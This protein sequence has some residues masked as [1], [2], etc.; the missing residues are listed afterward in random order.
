M[1]ELADPQRVWTFDELQQWLPEDVDPRRFEI[2]D[3]ALVV[4]PSAGSRH[5]I[6]GVGL[7]AVVR[8]ASPAGYTAAGALGIDLGGSYRVPDLVVV[9]VAGYVEGRAQADPRDVLLVVEV[10]SPGSRTTDRV[11][12]PAQYAAAGIPGYWRV[13]TDPAVTLTAYVLD[14]GAEAY[15]EIGTWGPGETARIERPFDVRVAIDTL[16]PKS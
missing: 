14:L 1:S 16:T 10:V 4:S 7:A 15:T 5:E 6:V 13:E 2:L 9:P 11:V 3:G 8:A 12:K